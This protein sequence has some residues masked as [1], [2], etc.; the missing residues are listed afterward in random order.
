[1]SL[2]PD[3]T[4]VA[5][6]GRAVL[7][8]LR[9]VGRVPRTAHSGR[10]STFSTYSN[11]LLGAYMDAAD[12][13]VSNGVGLKIEKSLYERT[14]TKKNLSLTCNCVAWHPRLSNIIATGA[15]NGAV[16]FWDL[17]GRLRRKGKVGKKIPA[18]VQSISKVHDACVNSVSWHPSG[19]PRYLLSASVDKSVCLWDYQD[20]EE[21][22][23]KFECHTK[24]HD[25]RFNPISPYEFA[26][27]GGD[28]SIQIWDTRNPKSCKDKLMAHGRHVNSLDWHPE[29]MNILASGG[30][31]RTIKV[32][33][34][35]VGKQVR[36]MQALA[37]V[38]QVQWRPGYPEQIASSCVEVDL[39][40]SVWD[41][42]SPNVPQSCF[43]GH[44]DAIPGLQW[45][46][47]D[48]SGSGETH[49][50]TCSRDKTVGMHSFKDAYC[51][52]DSARR[53]GLC[54][55]PLNDIAIVRKNAVVTSSISFLE[56]ETLDGGSGTGNTA[57][58]RYLA[59][60]Y[61]SRTSP[62]EVK[63]L[64]DVC[65]NNREAALAVG[66][67]MTA[68]TWATVGLMLGKEERTSDG[69]LVLDIPAAPDLGPTPGLNFSSRQGVAG[70]GR[71][72]RTGG[73]APRDMKLLMAPGDA[74]HKRGKAPD[75]AESSLVDDSTVRSR[76]YTYEGQEGTT[77]NPAE[78]TI[79]DFQDDDMLGFHIRQAGGRQ[80]RA[81]TVE[82]EERYL[83]DEDGSDVGS[84]ASSVNDGAFSMLIQQ[85][86]IAN[87]D[88]ADGRMQD[89]SEIDQHRNSS[90]INQKIHADK[91][92]PRK[93]F[94]QGYGSP[95]VSP[96]SSP[97]AS[98]DYFGHHGAGTFSAKGE[99][100]GGGAGTGADGGSNGRK[101]REGGAASRGRGRGVGHRS[102][103]GGRRREP[104][105]ESASLCADIRPSVFNSLL[106]HYCNVEGDVQ[107]CA[108]LADMA[109]Q[110]G[111]KF[112]D[113]RVQSW[114]HAYIELLQRHSLPLVA[115]EFFS[116]LPGSAGRMN[117]AST[118]L[119]SFCIK[120]SRALQPSQGPVCD[121]CNSSLAV[122]VVCEQHVSG[123]FTWCQGC[124]H[125]G[126][127][128]HM[129][130]WFE[131]NSECPSGCGHNCKF[132]NGLVTVQ[133]KAPLALGTGGRR[134]AGMKGGNPGGGGGGGGSYRFRA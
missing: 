22:K 49:L 27:G 55:S 39:S 94:L 3:Q 35:T 17:E 97:S 129:R 52:S 13:G 70:G 91:M 16:V 111:V 80:S 54:I 61:K 101:D 59:G 42:R 31:D 1:M 67:S 47:E 134:P 12:A 92:E 10:S 125:G 110:C 18:N 20:S 73:R 112:D 2:C 120:C 63:S 69:K 14:K 109:M 103:Q 8:I 132:N 114:F 115:A 131:D 41:I 9:I 95:S 79:M 119:H 117:Q 36:E 90:L 53:H 88:G 26:V 29:R 100:F 123:V 58:F 133:R 57:T 118:T 107:M 106:D 21:P 105:P 34:M 74:L 38:S 122:C 126:H 87:P 4:L 71:D 25:V 5:V 98:R 24:V 43:S 102:P 30:S 32:W 6:G 37:S 78:S 65:E 76:G 28:G 60:K 56:R 23:L 124:G 89:E 84:N 19:D 108:I 15:T 45:L 51:P 113:S 127:L 128:E 121:K 68:Q 44:T 62:P 33:D 66:R 130:E 82:D 50:L 48:G 75:D 7:N 11:E 81:M 99:G 83:N 46:P 86:D 96:R 72:R 77:S 64:F 104:P 40:I 85:L 93:H 116:R